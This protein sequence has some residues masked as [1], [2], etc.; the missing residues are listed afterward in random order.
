MSLDE[1]KMK[2]LKAIISTYLETGEPVGSRTIARDSDLHLSSATIRNEMADLEELGYILQPHTSAGRIPSDLGY[3]YYVDHLMEERETEFAARESEFRKERQELLQKMDR[4]EEV[5]KNVADALAANTN[6]ATLI[7]T[8]QIKE[9]KLKF[10][11]LSMVDTRR[12]LAVIVVGNDTVR[13]L[14]MNIDES[15][16]NDEILKLNILLN[17]FLQGLTLKEIN[18]EL[19]HTMKVQAGMHASILEGIFNGIVEAIHEA[20]DMEIY[21]SGATNM[22]KYPELMNPDHTTALLDTLVEKKA[23]VKL[24]DDTVNQEERHGIQVYIGNETPVQSLKDCS[25]VTATYE[26]EEGG[27]GTVGIIGPKRMDYQ[28]VVNTLKNLTDDLDEIFNNKS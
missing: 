13:N 6:Y 15:L 17:S 18:L 16:A 28:K 9:S 27:T 19:V 2:I 24:V 14:L 7:T 25:I 11:Q 12:L 10:I 20:D 1:R 22:L 21:T 3:R 8:P 5:L 26:L 4:M 23:L